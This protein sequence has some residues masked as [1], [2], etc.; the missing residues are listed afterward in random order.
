M[1]G[2]VE[3][4]TTLR[5]LGG[6]DAGDGLWERVRRAAS[7]SR[8]LAR[9]RGGP[10]RSP[11]GER[12]GEAAGAG[13]EAKVLASK[14]EPCSNRGCLRLPK[15]PYRCGFLSWLPPLPGLVSLASLPFMTSV[16]CFCLLPA[17][18]CCLTFVSRCVVFLLSF[19]CRA[20][21][22]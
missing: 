11:G 12:G 8:A 17:C 21:A 20:R 3:I 1:N 16:S 13:E 22:Q 19:P 6:L 10:G 2:L 18:L 5:C 9:Q 15:I 4:L 14:R 7:V